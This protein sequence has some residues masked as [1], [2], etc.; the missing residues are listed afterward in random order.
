MILRNRYYKNS[1]YFKSSSISRPL[2][3]CGMTFGK[4]LFLAL[5]STTSLAS[6]IGD[7]SHIFRQLNIDTTYLNKT[8][9]E[10]NICNAFLSSKHQAQR[11]HAVNDRAERGVKL[12]SDFAK[13]AKTSNSLQNTLQV[14]EKSSYNA[15]TFEKGDLFYID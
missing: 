13:T 1:K 6:L 3:K 2:K 5:D 7:F 11:P 10:W 8:V 14:V 15:P 12:T 4:P 9:M